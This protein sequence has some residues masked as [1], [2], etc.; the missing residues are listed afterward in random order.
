MDEKNHFL[1]T[2]LQEAAANTFGD[3]IYGD[4]P[5]TDL[6]NK[7]AQLSSLVSFTEDSLINIPE[8]MDKKFAKRCVNGIL[9]EEAENILIDLQKKI[10][11][12]P[13]ILKNNPDRFKKGIHMIL[14][15]APT[16]SGPVRKLFRYLEETK[17][18]SR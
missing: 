7:M 18:E 14:S 5:Q 12:G 17:Q 9:M 4:F 8:G 15:L 6:Y 2:R 10:D 3:I 1:F 16:P 11:K 13:R